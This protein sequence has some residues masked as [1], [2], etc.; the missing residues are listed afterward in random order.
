MENEVQEAVQPIEK[1]GVDVKKVIGQVRTVLDSKKTMAVLI[2]LLLIGIVFY[3]KD[4]F[5]AATIDGKTI[6]RF[7][8]IERLEKQSGKQALDSMI[9]EQ[10][11]E[12]EAQQQGLA[13]T[14]EEVAAEIKTIEASVTAQGSTLEEAL[15][16]Q[17]LAMEDFKKSLKLQKA[18]EKLLGDKIKVT[19]EEIN[20]SLGDKA[21]IPAGKE[22]EI[23]G[24]ITEQ[25]K[26][27]KLNQEASKYIEELRAKAKIKYFMQYE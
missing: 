3:F 21:G 12:N 17:G 26:S 20:K 15:A 9:T 5:L 22:E 6:S 10:L 19:E 23:R 16:G 18:L 8:V 1:K 11:I 4:Y 14:D 25:L 27:Q 2:V 7:S 13:V 24:Q